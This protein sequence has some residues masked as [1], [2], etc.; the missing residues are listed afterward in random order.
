MLALLPPR[1]LV[2]TV[3]KS[4][5]IAGIDHG[6][7][8]ATGDSFSFS[9]SFSLGVSEMLPFLLFVFFTLTGEVFGG[10]TLTGGRLAVVLGGVLKGVAS[11]TAIVLLRFTAAE[12]NLDAV[13]PV[14]DVEVVDNTGVD[15]TASV[16]FDFFDTVENAD[17]P[18]FA[19]FSTTG[20][21]FSTGLVESDLEG[22]GELRARKASSDQR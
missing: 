20:S 22:G 6:S 4:S 5:L 1:F 14:R 21:F 13:T 8:P 7:S 11:S 2:F 3:P 9:F 12:A 16:G 19:F 18:C 10:E 17:F 15:K